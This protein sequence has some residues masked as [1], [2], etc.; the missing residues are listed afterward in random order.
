MRIEHLALYVSDLEGTKSFYQK[1]FG[2]AP[3]E[4]YHNPR[5]G[6]KTYFLSFESGSRLEIMQKPTVEVRSSAVEHTGY[7]HL[8]FVVGTEADVDSLTNALRSEGY[9]VVSEPRT[10][11][12]GYYESVVLD[13]EGN[14]IE[15]VQKSLIRSE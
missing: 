10:T 3:N 15:L 7:I 4:L 14:R 6:L 8:A 12:D 9:P 5:T 11:G 2:A 13:P 1:Y